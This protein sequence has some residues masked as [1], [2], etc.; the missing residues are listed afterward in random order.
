MIK[1]KNLLSCKENIGNA[2]ET[3][4]F[5]EINDKKT[6]NIIGEKEISIR[7]FNKNSTR[8]T[9]MLT[10]LGNGKSLKPFVIFNGTS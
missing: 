9:V 10:I 7:S 1:D 3:P 2:D 6:L 8:I 5:I 4:V